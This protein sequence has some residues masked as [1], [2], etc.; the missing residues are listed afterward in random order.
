[1]FGNV[2][3]ITKFRK[4]T[5][6][7]SDYNEPLNQLKHMA[8]TCHSALKD[9]MALASCKSY[10]ELV[11]R[12][13]ETY[14]CHQEA[15]KSSIQDIYK[16]LMETDRD[17]ALKIA[18]C[19]CSNSSQKECVEAQRRLHPPCAQMKDSPPINQCHNLGRDCRNDRVCRYVTNSS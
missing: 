16:H 3:K 2:N 5:K 8:G 4:F 10:L 7:K 17:L 15:C 6:F 9:C 18:L 11:S 13:C 14:N 19:V 1:M 12:H